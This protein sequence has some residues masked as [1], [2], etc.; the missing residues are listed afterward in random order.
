MTAAII[1]IGDEILIGQVQDTNSMYIANSLVEA[2]VT[3]K[4]ILT[5]GD[6]NDA[7]INTLELATGKYDHIF[8]TGGLGP[9]KD[10]ITKN[11]FLEY[12]GGKL[13]LHEELL[14]K[15]KERFE[16]INLTSVR[17][18]IPTAVKLY[19]INWAQHREC[20]FKR[21]NQ[22]FIQCPAFRTKWNRCLQAG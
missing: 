7:I 15:L 3:L 21:R 12:F 6:D 22:I 11:A 20:I 19:Q 1:I 8:V 2:G 18:N 16:S 4:S 17:R 14:A 13:I 5:V 10:D 9:T